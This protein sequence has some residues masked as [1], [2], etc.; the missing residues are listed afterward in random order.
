[1]DVR[2]AADETHQ[3]LKRSNW[4]AEKR[5]GMGPDQFDHIDWML[6]GIK[7]GYIVGEK[8]HRWLGWTQGIMCAHQGIDLDTFKSINKRA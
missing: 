2:V 6:I 4:P 3:R 8:A 1:M 5:V 7:E